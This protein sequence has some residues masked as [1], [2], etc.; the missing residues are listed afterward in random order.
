MGLQSYS[1][2]YPD[3]LIAAIYTSARQEIIERIKL[4][5]QV[6]AGYVVLASAVLAVAVKEN[7]PISVLALPYAAFGAACLTRQ[8][9]EVIGAIWRY[10]AAEFERDLRAMESA[11]AGDKREPPPPPVPVTQWDRSRSLLSLSTRPFYRI[12]LVHLVL[13]V[14]PSVFSQVFVLDRVLRAG[15]AVIVAWIVGWALI[16]FTLYQVWSAAADR[17]ALRRASFRS[18][19]HRLG[20]PARERDFYPHFEHFPEEEGRWPDS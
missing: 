6:T 14:C 8:H 2:H 9:Q 16:V 11:S 20:Y 18:V 17:G 4:R 3:H 5:D 19:A 13:L 15:N 1:M 12:L 7:A 10:L